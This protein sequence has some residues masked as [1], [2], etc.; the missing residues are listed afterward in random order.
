LRDKREYV[1]K[2]NKKKKKYE[3]EEEEK[4]QSEAKKIKP[5]ATRAIHQF[6]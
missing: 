2:R 5:Q 4:K 1:S 6:N 3:Q